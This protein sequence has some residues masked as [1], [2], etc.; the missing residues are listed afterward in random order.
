M[1]TRVHLSHVNNAAGDSPLRCFHN[2]TETFVQV[3]GVTGGRRQNITYQFC[4]GDNMFSCLQ[5]ILTGIVFYHP[6]LSWHHLC[7]LRVW[8]RFFS[9]WDICFLLVFFS[10]VHLSVLEM[11][12][13][14][15][16]ESCG[17]SPAVFSHWLILW[18]F[19]L[20]AGQGETPKRVRSLTLRHLC[21]QEC[22]EIIWS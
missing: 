9:S 5:Q 20:G 15:S 19:Y 12:L 18:G 3:R 6:K 16:S 4:W 10:I 13:L 7:P 8:Q 14:A 11:S 17:G 1:N 2:N 21:S 22:P